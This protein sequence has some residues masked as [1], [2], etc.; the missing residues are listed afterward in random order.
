[1]AAVR[2]NILT[3]QIDRDRFIQACTGLKQELTGLT[4]QELGI[5]AGPL[6]ASKDLSTWD[7]FVLWHLRA[8]QQISSDGARNAAHMGPVF[9]PW[10]RWYMLVL[11]FEM[12]RILGV[13][14]DDF[15]IPYWDFAADG[16]RSPQEQ[17]DSSQLWLHIGGTGQAF[18]GEL[19]EGPF[20]Y[21]NF[22]VNID[23]GQTGA[24]RATDRGLRRQFGQRAPSLPT[25]AHEQEVMN[26]PTYD[27]AGFD[28]Q[29]AGF[30]NQL[31]GWIPAFRA[32]GMHNRVHVWAGGDMLPGTSPNDPLFFLNHC[33]VDRIWAAWQSNQIDIN[34]QPT[35]RSASTADPLYR[36]RSDDPMYSILTGEPPISAMLDV[37]EFYTYN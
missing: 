10:H 32:P 26:A 6:A 14:R 29:S 11:E 19:T 36:Q 17:I 15:A 35:G 2:N 8:M 25:L 1:M 37:S 16:E 28:G 13:G 33:N 7:L 20:T 22:P 24:L 5:E 4:T 30:R 23:T 21:S 3:S 18:N 31:E 27:Q 12:R 9:L 34:Y